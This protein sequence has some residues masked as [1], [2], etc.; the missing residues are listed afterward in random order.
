MAVILAAVAA[1]L[2]GFLGGLMAARV[3]LWCDS[4][5]R[6]LEC[7]EHGMTTVSEARS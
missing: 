5:G 7:P 6:S 1:L 3:K 4:C 2:V